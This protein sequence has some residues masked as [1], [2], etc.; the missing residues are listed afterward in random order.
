M[1]MEKRSVHVHNLKLKVMH[2]IVVQLW[3][4]FQT[5]KFPVGSVFKFYHSVC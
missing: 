3:S 4:C 5:V 1:L 2:P